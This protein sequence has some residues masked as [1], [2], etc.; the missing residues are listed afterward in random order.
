[1]LSK[2]SKHQEIIKTLKA[3]NF[4]LECPNTNEEV[5]IKVI[6]VFDNDNFTDDAIEI[7]QQQLVRDN[8]MT[9]IF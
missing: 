7:Y 3:G 5:S 4:Y 8:S 2:N 9:A 6:P 1:M